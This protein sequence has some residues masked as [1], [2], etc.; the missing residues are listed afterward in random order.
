ME[1]HQNSHIFILSHFIILY[2][3]PWK[4]STNICN[5]VGCSKLDGGAYSRYGTGQDFPIFFNELPSWMLFTSLLITASYYRVND[6]LHSSKIFVSLQSSLLLLFPL[7][8]HELLYCV[9]KFG[10]ILVAM[11]FCWNWS[12]LCMLSCGRFCNAFQLFM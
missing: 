6:G 1:L 11:E 4:F 3:T 5:I 2:I 7:V 12:P 8:L 10:Q 9:P